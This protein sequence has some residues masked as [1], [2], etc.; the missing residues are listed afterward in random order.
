MEVEAVEEHLHI[1]PA[2]SAMSA[3]VTA[4]ARSQAFAAADRQV[5]VVSGISAILATPPRPTMEE[6]SRHRQPNQPSPASTPGYKPEEGQDSASTAPSPDHNRQS[7]G[8]INLNASGSLFRTPPPR[9]RPPRP[10]PS[11]TRGGLTATP[12]AAQ[13]STTPRPHPATRSPLA[14]L[15]SRTPKGTGGRPGSSRANLIRTRTSPG[16]RPSRGRTRLP[17]GSPAGAW[18]T[19]RISPWTT[20]RTMVRVSPP[21]GRHPTRQ[22]PRQRQQRRQQ[23][24]V[25]GLP[26]E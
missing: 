23:L 8:D 1:Q 24:Q 9:L 11:R 6:L 18:P 5:P 15:W 22:P 12:M 21:Q 3:S 19:P 25:L 20:P 10:C 2:R 7:E 16:T 26:A 14:T 4:L 13:G 17:S